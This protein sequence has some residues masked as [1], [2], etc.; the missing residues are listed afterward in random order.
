M[1]D[2]LAG[3]HWRVHDEVTRPAWTLVGN[4]AEEIARV[5]DVRFLTSGDKGAFSTF[6]TPSQPLPTFLL[7]SWFGEN[8]EKMQGKK[9]LLM[10]FSA[11]PIK[12]IELH[13]E[14]TTVVLSVDYEDDA[15]LHEDNKLT[16]VEGRILPLLGSHRFRLKGRDIRFFLSFSIPRILVRDFVYAMMRMGSTELHCDADDLKFAVDEFSKK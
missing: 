2:L 14:G 4:D 12:I 7:Q 16:E 13:F 10:G 8:A 5:K 11:K 6:G 9:F 1:T 15:T 3:Q